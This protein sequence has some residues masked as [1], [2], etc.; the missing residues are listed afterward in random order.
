M[1]LFTLF[2][3]SQLLIAGE[4]GTTGFNFL[5]LSGGAK[6]IAMG[7]TC[8]GSSKGVGALFLNPA[9]V[10]QP[11]KPQASITYLSYVADIN[12]G[13]LGYTRPSERMGYGI[14]IAYLN[15]GSMKR[16]DIDN[17]DLGTFSAQYLSLQTALGIKPSPDILL[18]TG[19]KFLYATIDTFWSM[20]GA[21]DIGGLYIHKALSMGI[22]IQNLGLQVKAFDEEKDPLPLNL[23]IG[24]GY[25]LSEEFYISLDINKP[26]DNRPN[27]KLGMEWRLHKNFALRTGYDSMRQD[28]KTQGGS[29]ILAGFSFGM[30]IEH[31][32]ITLDYAY[33]P[34]LLLGNSHRISLSFW[35]K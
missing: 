20:G 12:S 24:L 27:L 19:I 32:E 15:S 34:Y 4:V 6:E 31:K 8:L 23:G 26:I 9:G 1:R 3:F 21:M 17:N 18:G 10:I 35:F 29:D 14:G 25:K 13:F 30:G 11:D 16:T 33:T 2:L 28:L 7:G 5:K 22:A